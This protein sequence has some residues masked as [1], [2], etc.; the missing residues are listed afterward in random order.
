MEPRLVLGKRA[1]ADFCCSE[2]KR[3]TRKERTRTR[4]RD[5]RPRKRVQE[6]KEG[7]QRTENQ[8]TASEILDE[9]SDHA[10]SHWEN[11]IK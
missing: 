9:P 10:S 11:K 3:G 6:E 8:G 1:R 2:R 7:R 5:L 4:K